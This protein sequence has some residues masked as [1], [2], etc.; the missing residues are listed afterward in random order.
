MRRFP[1]KKL[2][3]YFF[4]KIKWKQTQIIVLFLYVVFDPKENRKRKMKKKKRTL[5]HL[6]SFFFERYESDILLH[7]LHKS[8]NFMIIWSY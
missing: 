7:K 8:I 2:L 6:S 4:K 3:K 5:N 1:K